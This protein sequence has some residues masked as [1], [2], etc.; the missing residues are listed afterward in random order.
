VTPRILGKIKA[1]VAVKHLP[2]RHAI[3]A[4][5]AAADEIEESYPR[6]R[7][8]YAPPPP[9]RLPAPSKKKKKGSRK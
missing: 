4:L 7:L 8:V 9:K 1:L 5:R 6:P 2:P 3:A